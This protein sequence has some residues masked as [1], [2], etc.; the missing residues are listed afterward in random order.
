MELKDISGRL[1][2]LESLS[3]T[4]LPPTRTLRPKTTRV[5]SATIRTPFIRAMIPVGT[6]ENGGTCGSW[7]LQ[8][9]RGAKSPAVRNGTT[10]TRSGLRM[11]RALLL[12][13]TARE[14]HTTTAII[15]TYG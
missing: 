10:R 12:C 5:T 1:M 8:R 2:E 3:A 7:M 9:E 13:R 4:H 15:Q 14:R 11:A 6:M